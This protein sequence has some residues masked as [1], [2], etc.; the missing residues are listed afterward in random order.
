MKV[1]VTGATGMVGKG[2]LLECLDHES[3]EKVLV[4]GRNP[5]DITHPKLEEL[6]HN[7]F[8]DFSTVKGQLAGYDACFLCMGISSVGMKEDDFKKITYDFTLSL[9]RELF[10]LNPEMTITYVSGEGT[11][12]SEKGKVMWAR[13][14]GKTEN[15]LIKLGFKQA[16]MF[17]PG[18]IIPLRGIKSRTKA[19]QFIYDYFMWLVR[20]V[21]ALAPNAVVNTTQVGKAMIKAVLFGYNSVIIKPKDIIQLAEK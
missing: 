2:V 17:R 18:L 12:S 7:D 20:L 21:K 4:I 15:D 5:V 16:F 9:A 11:D 13:V 8:S 14:K 3:V 6:I 1:I 10:P 19:Y